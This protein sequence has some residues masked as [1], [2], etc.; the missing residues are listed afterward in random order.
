MPLP[1]LHSLVVDLKK[2][3]LIGSRAFSSASSYPRIDTEREDNRSHWF[4]TT[5]RWNLLRSS[6]PA[7]ALWISPQCPCHVVWVIITLMG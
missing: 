6:S 1:Y 7:G 3:F 2:A 4:R 5:A